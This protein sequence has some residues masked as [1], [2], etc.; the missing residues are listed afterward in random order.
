MA[1]REMVLLFSKEGEGNFGLNGSDE[2]ARGLA[3][4]LQDAALLPVL[5]RRGQCS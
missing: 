4:Y 3:S 1:P 5:L 2:W